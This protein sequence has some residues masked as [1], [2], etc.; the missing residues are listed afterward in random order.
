MTR[1]TVSPFCDSTEVEIQIRL[2]D[3]LLRLQCAQVAFSQLGANAT[4]GFPL[5]GILGQ[6]HEQTIRE[7]V[8]RLALVDVG[9]DHLG[10]ASVV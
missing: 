9:R 5:H 10:R 4:N 7:L 8:T 2:A 6:A 1:G 3:V